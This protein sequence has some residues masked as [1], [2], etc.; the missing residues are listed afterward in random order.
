MDRE[1]S[2]MGQIQWLKTMMSPSN[3][4]VKMA[5][6]AQ[7]LSLQKECEQRKRA[8]LELKMMQ[9]AN[10]ENLVEAQAILCQMRKLLRID[11]NIFVLF[12]LL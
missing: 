4:E 5:L 12:L 3:E 7:K 8:E 2:S 1:C 9:A 10:E 6:P 11:V